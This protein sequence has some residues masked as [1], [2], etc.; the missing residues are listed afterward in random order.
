MANMLDYLRWRGDLALDEESLNDVD[1]LVLAQLSY[2]N[3]DTLLPNDGDMACRV[4]IG[5]ACGRLTQADPQGRTIRQIGYLWAGNR[6]L[7]ELL[8]AC[9]RFAG[10]NMAGYQS[11]LDQEAQTQFGAAAYLLPDGGAVVAFRG[12]DDSLAGW[13]EDM[14]LSFCDPV[15]A[16]LEAVSFLERAAGAVKGRLYLCGHSKGGNLAVYAAACARPAVESRIERVCCFD[17]PG[18]SQTLIAGS[19]YA[20]VRGR[21]RLYVPHFSVVGMLLEHEDA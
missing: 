9:P 6:Q 13:K 5:Q 16:Q 2:V 20:R 15:P 1:L 14:N 19:G 21:L 4:S 11:I 10:L 7:I 18:Q 8:S 17:G 12:T 3:F